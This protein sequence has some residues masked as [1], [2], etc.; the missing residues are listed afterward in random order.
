MHSFTCPD[1]VTATL[2]TAFWSTHGNHEVDITHLNKHNQSFHW[3]C[4]TQ[5]LYI[6]SMVSYPCDSRLAVMKTS[7]GN[8]VG[9]DKYRKW[10][11][12]TTPILQPAYGTQTLTT[13]TYPTL[14]RYP[15]ATA[16]TIKI[17]KTQRYPKVPRYQD[18][19]RY[20][21]I[22]RYHRYPNHPLKTT[23]KQPGEARTDVAGRPSNTM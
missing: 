21:G 5:A 19:Q 7:I 9:C 10:H 17:P 3:V 8:L 11:P 6:I 13:L 2:S 14:S 1:A 18:T 15:K 12:R 16:N 20:Q 22:P 4:D 23:N